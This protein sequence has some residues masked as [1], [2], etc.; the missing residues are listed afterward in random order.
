MTTRPVLLLL[1]ALEATA[2]VL[3]VEHARTPL[4]RAITPSLVMTRS[5][6]PSVSK[7]K[8]PPDVCHLMTDAE[9][10]IAHSLFED[11]STCARRQTSPPTPS[12]SHQ[13]VHARPHARAHALPSRHRQVCVV[14]H[15]RRARAGALV[16]VLP[17]AIVHAFGGG[18]RGMDVH[19]WRRLP[20]DGRG[21]SR[22]AAV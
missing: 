16:H 17:H 3:P 13:H 8:A 4:H 7:V 12:D 1:A 2:F 18:L 20:A 21:V 15:V 11:D 22:A 14:V 9:E 5:E 19:H 6:V 10:S